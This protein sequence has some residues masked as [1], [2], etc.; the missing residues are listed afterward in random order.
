MDSFNPNR[1]RLPR[2]H[3]DQS[4]SPTQERFPERRV[5]PRQKSKKFLKGPVPLSWLMVAAQLS[6]KSLAVGIALWFRS[7]LERSNQVQLPTTL[8]NLFGIDRHAKARA[9]DSLEKASLIAVERRKGKNPIVTLL[10]VS[11]RL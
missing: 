2:N 10:E 3:N 9:L 4:E 6:G 7:G 5:I 8:L 11:E 1:F